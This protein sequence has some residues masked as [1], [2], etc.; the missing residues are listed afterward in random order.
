MQDSNL[1]AVNLDLL[2]PFINALMPDQFF[3]SMKADLHQMIVQGNLGG[4]VLSE[5]QGKALEEWFEKELDC[6]G[7]LICF[8]LAELDQFIRGIEDEDV[9]LKLKNPICGFQAEG[10]S[11]LD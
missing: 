3:S 8:Y 6:T 10:N 9:S 1:R 11:D 7:L 4:A 2:P 5:A